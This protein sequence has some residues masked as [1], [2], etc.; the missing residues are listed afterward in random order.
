MQEKINHH[1]KMAIIFFIMIFILGVFLPIYF[2][3]YHFNFIFFCGVIL[4]STFVI[5]FFY[6]IYM[7]YERT[8]DFKELKSLLTKKNKA[9][10][11]KIIHIEEYPDR[12][13]TFIDC[14]GITRSIPNKTTH[15]E[16]YVE[17]V[18]IGKQ[19]M[20][21]VRTRTVN[22]Y[23]FDLIFQTESGNIYGITDDGFFNNEDMNIYLIHLNEEYENYKTD[24]LFIPFQKDY[25]RNNTVC[26]K[27]LK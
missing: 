11:E 20:P 25:F 10:L 4:A 21:Q 14:H 17:N 13:F 18:M 23:E 8:N 12:S 24:N 16:T 2:Q 19:L 27:L 3:T 5:A 7:F 9:T 22:N 15:T 6:Q 26:V 1:K